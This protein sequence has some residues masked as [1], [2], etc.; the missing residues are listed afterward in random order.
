MNTNN[1]IELTSD[2]APGRAFGSPTAVTSVARGAGPIPAVA[3]KRQETITT[4]G[5]T[6]IRPFR[7]NVSEAELTE[8]RMRIKATR[9]PE[10]E[11]VA[12]T[13][14]GVPLVPLQDLARYWATDYDW[15]KAEAKLNALPQ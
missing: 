6:A 3:G 4:E 2:G 9:W 10:K 13:S 8:L 15:R 11:T 14:Q 5:R 7:V 1:Q 12:D